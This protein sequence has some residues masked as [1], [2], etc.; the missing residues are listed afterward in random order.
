MIFQMKRAL[1]IVLASSVCFTRCKKD[2]AFLTNQPY[3]LLTSA[4]AYSSVGSATSVLAGL[5][6]QYVDLQTITNDSSFTQFDEA[7]PSGG[8]PSVQ[9]TSNYAYPSWQ[10]WNYDYIR[11]INLFIQLCGS[12]P[13]IDAV[14]KGQLI[15]EAK[16]L[17]AADYFEMAKRMGGVPLIFE[18]LTYDFSGGVDSLLYARSRESDIYDFVISTMDTL[19]AILPKDATVQ[20]R[21]TRGVCLAMESRAALY[22]ASIAN[23]GAATPSAVLPGDIVGIPASKATAYYQKALAS[24]QELINDGTYSLYLKTPND[25]TANFA[26]LFLDKASNPEVIFAQNFKLRSGSVESWTL[27]CQPHAGAEVPSVNGFVNPSLNLAMQYEML[28]NTY[29]PFQTTDGRGGYI[30]YSDSTALFA[31]R[32]A[33]LAATFILPGSQFKGQSVDIWAGYMLADGTIV[34]SGTYGGLG[35]LPGQQYAVPVVGQSGPIDGLTQTAETGFYVRKFLDPT[36]GSGTVGTQ[37][38]VWWVRYRFGEVLLNAAEAAYALGN[39]GTAAEYLNQVRARA[40][41]TIPL[42]PSDINFDRLVHE[43]RVELAFEGHEFFDNKR[44]RIAD[45]VWNGQPVTAAQLYASIGK[46]A[47]PD[48]QIWAIYPYKIYNPGG[49]NDGKWVYEIVKP[50]KVTGSYNFSLGNYYAQIPPLDIS[51]NPK[52]IQNPNQ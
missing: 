35:V 12:S 44:W 14:S 9:M 43:R 32:D 33:R 42:Q 16:F 29:A 6:G 41:L 19:K 24:A 8:D 48:T 11:A 52:L 22:A 1:I 10:L 45:K 40:G 3:T 26:N 46:A 4:Q 2:S 36:P 15:G 25:L 20:D 13:T 51:S 30:Y 17:R 49:P 18:P 31:G 39:A 7:Y 50:S 5:Y 38:E 21:A 34:T 37:S 27:D 47:A 28:N 23:Y